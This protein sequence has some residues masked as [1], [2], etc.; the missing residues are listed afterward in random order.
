MDRIVE[1]NTNREKRE[2]VDI[3]RK[4]CKMLVMSLVSKN[5]L[6]ESK[7]SDAV[8]DFIKICFDVRCDENKEERIAGIDTIIKEL[9]AAK[10]TQ[11][12]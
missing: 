5:D 11:S 2:N 4:I 12:K 3:D 10:I 7:I 1:W 9:C 6:R 8:I